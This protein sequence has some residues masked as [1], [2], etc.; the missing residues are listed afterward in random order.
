M[1][2][3]NNHIRRI[4]EESDLDLD[5]ATDLAR[6]LIQFR[7]NINK[8]SRDVNCPND[9]QEILEAVLFNAD[10]PQ[11]VEVLDD[12]K[13]DIMYQAYF[14][15]VASCTDKDIDVQEILKIFLNF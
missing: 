6:L 7:L 14:D 2:L 8:F 13:K 1:L 11:R 12:D 15:F 3:D 4:L 5:K 9:Y 10:L